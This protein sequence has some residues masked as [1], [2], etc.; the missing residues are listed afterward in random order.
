MTNELIINGKDAYT[1]WGIGLVDGAIAT[2]IAPPPMKEYISNSSRLEHGSRYISNP[3][4]AKIEERT[5]TLEMHL[6]A[7]DKGDFFNKYN[8]FCEEL[9]KGVLKIK[10]LYTGD[11][12]YTCLYESCTQFSEFKLGIGKFVL[13][14]IEPNPYNRT[15][16]IPNLSNSDE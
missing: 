14:L 3:Q 16:E 1:E 5:L 4:I 11:N 9:S 7:N 2:L 13:R 12:I 6:I 8:S 10:T 15:G